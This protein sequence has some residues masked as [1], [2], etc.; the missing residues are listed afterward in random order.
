V[1]VHFTKGRRTILDGPF[2]E[3][4]ELVA[5]YSILRLDSRDE[6]LEWA[7]R[8]AALIGDVEIDIRP[9]VEPADGC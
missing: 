7:S 1:R 2:A 5:G 4:K 3:S 8:F 9:L 6:V